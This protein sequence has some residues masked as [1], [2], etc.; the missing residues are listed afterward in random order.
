MTETSHCVYALKDP[1][2][3]LAK[4]V[5]IGKVRCTAP[6]L[7]TGAGRPGPSFRTARAEPARLDHRALLVG[8]ADRRR[9]PRPVLRQL[10]EQRIAVH[11]GEHRQVRR[12]V[13]EAGVAAAP[14]TGLGKTTHVEL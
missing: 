4:P 11:R 9:G 14:R 2:T 1:R 10:E 6:G 13:L 8:E 12:Q 5:Y 3:A 7:M